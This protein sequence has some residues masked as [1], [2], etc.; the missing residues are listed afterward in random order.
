MPSDMQKN[1]QARQ[2]LEQ[3][4]SE[5]GMVLEVRNTWRSARTELK[6]GCR[7]RSFPQELAR[8]DEG[9]CIYKL[10]GP[11]LIKQD[12]LEAKANVQ[13]RLDYIKAELDRL[14]TQLKTLETKANEKQAEVGWVIS[15]S[16]PSLSEQDVLALLMIWELP[17]CHPKACS[18]CPSSQAGNHMQKWLKGGC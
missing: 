7:N 1:V 16:G 12:Q 8:L 6:D 10:I 3:Q 14:D 9:A 15:S 2:Q 17:Q 4:S 11:A 18:M 13:K 5:N